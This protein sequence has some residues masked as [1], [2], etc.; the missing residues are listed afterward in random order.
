VF[1]EFDVNLSDLKT[2]RIATHL[3][4]DPRGNPADLEHL[5]KEGPLTG[6]ERYDVS[7]QEHYHLE[8]G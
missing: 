6:R 3:F 8:R 4:F 1:E 5:I 2:K 7:I